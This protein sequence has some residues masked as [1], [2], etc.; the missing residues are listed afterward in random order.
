[1]EG[2]KVTYGYELKY[3]AFGGTCTASVKG[4]ETPEEAQFAVWEMAKHVGYT[5]PRWWQCWRWAEQREPQQHDW[6]QIT[7]GPLEEGG[8]CRR[9]GVYATSGARSYCDDR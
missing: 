3:S 8:Q 6:M 5:V 4:C 7:E 2:K 1:M 9:C